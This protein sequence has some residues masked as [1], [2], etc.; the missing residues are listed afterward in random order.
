MRKPKRLGLKL[1]PKFDQNLDISSVIVL[2]F[3]E[4]WSI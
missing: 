1:D 4:F 3:I 2:Q